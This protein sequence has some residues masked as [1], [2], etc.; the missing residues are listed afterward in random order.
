ME[1]MTKFNGYAVSNQDG[2]V[3]YYGKVL[4]SEESNQYFGLLMQ[5]IQ[6]EKDKVI[7]FG[8]HIT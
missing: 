6:W 5:N 4:S 3:N 7:I 8:K 1:Q 2:M